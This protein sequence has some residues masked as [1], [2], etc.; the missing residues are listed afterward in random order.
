MADSLRL[1]LIRLAGVAA[2]SMCCDS[3]AADDFN[4]WGLEAWLVQQDA[5][6]VLPVGEDL[7]KDTDTSSFGSRLFFGRHINQ[8]FA[9]EAGALTYRTA[10]SRLFSPA[11]LEVLHIPA[12]SEVAIDFRAVITLPVADAIFFKAHAGPRFWS[13][14]TYQIDY[15][16]EQPT[17]SASQSTETG[18]TAGA[19]IG[20]TWGRNAAVL[21]GYEHMSAQPH[22]SSYVSLGIAFRID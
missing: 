7:I 10:P 12:Q 6:I 5:D 20:V 18:V 4:Y 19:N 3:V 14:R 9:V 15:P 2:L 13:L 22:D 16:A 21:L 8:F 17:F 11:Q 1:H